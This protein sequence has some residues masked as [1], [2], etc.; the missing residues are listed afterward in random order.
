V[1]DFRRWGDNET[2]GGFLRGAGFTRRNTRRAIL[3][4]LRKGLAA[5]ER[6]EDLRSVTY[7]L[8]MGFFAITDRRVVAG[9]S[10]AFLPFVK[11]RRAIPLRVLEPVE[12]RRRAWGTGLTLRG[13]GERIRVGN[14]EPDDA[15]DLKAR[16]EALA[17][18][19]R[20]APE[21][22]FPPPDASMVR[23]MEDTP[24]AP[25]PPETPATPPPPPP[26][27][28]PPGGPGDYPV[29]ADATRQEEYNRF[30]PLVK[31]LL[32]FPHYIVLLFLL[33]GAAVAIL[34][35]FFAVLFTRRYPR[36][37]FDYVV[38]VFRWG[39]RVSSYVYLLVDPYP[40]FTLADDPNYPARLQIPYPED[41]IDRWRPLVQWLL[42]I[43]YLI[44]AGIL[45]YVAAIVS[46]IGIF[47]ILFT[48]KLPEGMFK[49]ILNPMRWQVRGSA[50]ELWMVDKYPPF[51]WE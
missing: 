13:A 38:G 11:R 18:Q 14:L 4:F 30:L 21:S 35:S 32:A 27:Q 5:G 3:A 26:A 22:V 41:G 20:T 33:I 48:K 34:I 40:P 47:V 37:L 12:V 10:W 39:W 28:P 1:A 29:Q 36:G 46:F 44:V 17:A 15:A 42:A 23:N 16:L 19:A 8:Q 9:M 49:L 6:V 51:E 43:P 24:A 50:Y 25:P 7:R 31:W 45:S 2:E